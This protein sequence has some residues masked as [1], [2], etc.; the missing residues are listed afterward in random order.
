[1]ASPS[2]W[3]WIAVTRIRRKG[4]LRIT[5]LISEILWLTASIEIVSVLSI[6][7]QISMVQVL[8]A[9]I[10]S[11]IVVLIIASSK[12]VWLCD[13]HCICKVAR[14]HLINFRWWKFNILIVFFTDVWTNTFSTNFDILILGTIYFFI[15]F[16]VFCILLT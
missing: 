7:S 9:L 5:I 10:L 3:I 12:F 2:I 13:C 16:Y 11:S 14:T 6:V 15:Y 8:K 4:L 1:M